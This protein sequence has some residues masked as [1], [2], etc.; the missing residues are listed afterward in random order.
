MPPGD[1]AMAAASRRGVGDAAPYNSVGGGALLRPWNFA[2]AATPPAG[3][4]HP[5]LRVMIMSD[6]RRHALMPPG[7]FAMAAASRRGVGF[8]IPP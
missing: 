4:G 5:A 6:V 1:F 3:W 8:I 7:D 2:V